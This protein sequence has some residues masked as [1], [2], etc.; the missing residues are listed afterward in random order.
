[1]FAFICID[2]FYVDSLGVCACDPGERY[3]RICCCCVFLKKCSCVRHWLR[4]RSLVLCLEPRYLLMWNGC[5]TVSQFFLFWR[6]D[7]EYVL[8]GNTKEKNWIYR[9]KKENG[10]TKIRRERRKDIFPS[11]LWPVEEPKLKTSCCPLRSADR[12]RPAY[13]W[14]CLWPVLTQVRHFYDPFCLFH[15][16]P[17]MQGIIA[18]FT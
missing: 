3:I 13:F 15:P 8:N 2:P 5:H 14:A 6:R 12:S 17:L 16:R 1:M 4:K 18:A 7:S 9:N 10:K 11:T